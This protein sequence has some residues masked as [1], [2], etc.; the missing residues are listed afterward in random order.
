[1]VPARA[2]MRSKALPDKL[3][4]LGLSLFIIGLSIGTSAFERFRLNIGTLYVHLYLFLLFPFFIYLTCTSLRNFPGLPLASLLTFCALYSISTLSAGSPSFNDI[5]KTAGSAA[6]LI[7]SALMVRSEKDFRAAV[8]GFSIS[9]GVLAFFGLEAADQFGKNTTSD[10]GNKNTYSLYAI[11]AILLAGYLLVKKKSA[12]V[13]VKGVLLV[14]TIMPIIQIF[15]GANRSGW[16][17]IAL[18]ALMLLVMRGLNIR[19]VLIVAV[20]GY[21]TY[22]A[23]TRF[24]TTDVFAWRVQETMKGNSSDAIRKALILEG[25]Q[26][27]LDNP[28]LGV[29]PQMLPYELG[30]RLETGEVAASHNVVAH[31]IGGS[32]LICFTSMIMTGVFLWRLKPVNPTVPLSPEFKEARNV[33]R[34]MLISWIFRGQFTAEVIYSPGF[35][36]GLGLAIG[37]C[38]VIA[39]RDQAQAVQRP[40]RPQVTLPGLPR[41][42]SI[43]R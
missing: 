15:M 20:L 22:F 11:P 7:T 35:N 33:L 12:S 3:T 14:F 40:V 9:I 5:A 19:A 17:G 6:T 37:L 8:L 10:M 31:L 23:I 39:R 36:L 43:A 42:P 27:G 29:S 2:P 21:G 25:I 38:M 41:L 26:V 24:G 16:A 30:R 32:G 34:M 28:I 13:V 4:F 1:M 18:I